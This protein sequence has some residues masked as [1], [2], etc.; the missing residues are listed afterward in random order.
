SHPSKLDL[1]SD[2]KAAGFLVIVFHVGVDG[3]DLSVARVATRVSE[4]GHDV[5]AEKIRERYDRNG[6]LIRQ[7]VL[8]ADLAH[9]FDNS[10]LNTPPQRVLTFAFGQLSHVDPQ[11]PAWAARIYA[12]DLTTGS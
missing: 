7:A 11:L 9:V 8:N 4:G 3:R 12:A 1:I 10:K 2:A 6:T 5:P